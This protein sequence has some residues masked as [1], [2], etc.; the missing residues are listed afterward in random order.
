MARDVL[1][2][3]ANRGIGLEFARQLAARG[4]RVVATCRNPDAAPE[5]RALDVQVEELDV[6]SAEQIARVVALFEGKPLDL[7]LNNAGVGVRHRALGEIDFGEMEEFYR[8]NTVAPLRL[9]EGLLPSLRQGSDRL[10][11]SLTSRMGSIQDNTSGGSYAYRASKAAL[12]MVTRSLSRDLEDESFRCAVL[13]PGW[14]KTSMGGDAAPVTAE[15]SV[16][17]MLRV[18]DSLDAESN[19]GFFDYTG[20]ALPW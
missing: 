3:G 12:N 9:A 1:L 14:V 11:V 18:I 7:L 5:L 16:G 19:G 8:V 17:G 20:E 13:H 2:T 4:D 10:I 15:Q 6:A